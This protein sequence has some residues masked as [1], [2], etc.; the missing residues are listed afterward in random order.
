VDSARFGLGDLTYADAL[1]DGGKTGSLILKTV[2]TEIMMRVI[3]FLLAIGLGA[4]VSAA[5]TGCATS[6]SGGEYSRHEVGVEETV[7][8]GTVM[9]VRNVM[10]GGTRSGVGT[11]SGAAIGGIAGSEL[12]QGR[13]SGIGT[14]LGA[15]AG[16]IVGSAAE[17]GGTRQKGYE[18]T[19]R[20]DSGRIVAIVQGANEVFK[21]GERVK[22]ISS[23]NKTRVT[24]LLP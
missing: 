6:M 8:F 20:L 15:V 11:V 21:P 17:E 5:L 16:G 2:Q 19:I 4:F 10:I 23:Q 13:G 3:H 7:Q 22:L 12:G 24:H 9:S 18:L 14:I 1:I